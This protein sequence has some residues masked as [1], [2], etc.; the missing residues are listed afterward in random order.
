M[1]AVFLLM[2]S[3]LYTIGRGYNR[4]GN[5]SMD[6]ADY[7]N[8]IFFDR[9]KLFKS[10]LSVVSSPNQGREI[11]FKVFFPSL[12]FYSSINLLPNS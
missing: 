2:K 4:Q 5:F 8:G 11:L 12:P 6:W 3:S 1:G 9:V 10:T 7:L